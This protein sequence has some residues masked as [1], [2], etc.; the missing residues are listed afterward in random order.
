MLENILPSEVNADLAAPTVLAV[1][2][3]CVV[4]G[5]Q[6]WGDAQRSPEAT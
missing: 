3:A 5:L 6:R 2:G 4:A 1:V